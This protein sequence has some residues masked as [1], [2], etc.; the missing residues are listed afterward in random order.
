MLENSLQDIILPWQVVGLDEHFHISFLPIQIKA[1]EKGFISCSVFYM[2]SIY[3]FH[4]WISYNN[5]KKCHQKSWTLTQTSSEMTDISPLTQGLQ[6]MS[7]DTHKNRS[8]SANAIRIQSHFL[9][10]T[11]DGKKQSRTG[12]LK[13][14]W[15][16]SVV[17][18][19]K[20]MFPTEIVACWPSDL[21]L[22]SDSLLGLV[23]AQR[24]FASFCTWSHKHVFSYS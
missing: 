19:L 16:S 21:A 1:L 23:C 17:T 15:V 12:T 5:L 22:D 13:V 4:K 9:S 18:L 7:F 24:K 8:I 3:G 2:K 20:V 6:S 14:V 11:Q 10:V